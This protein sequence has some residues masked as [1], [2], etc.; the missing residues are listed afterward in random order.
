MLI[1][2][3]ILVLINFALVFLFSL[4]D[5]EKRLALRK[6]PTAVKIYKGVKCEI[7]LSRR[8]SI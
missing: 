2:I 3:Y 4:K 6:V 5:N 8:G 1:N 7:E